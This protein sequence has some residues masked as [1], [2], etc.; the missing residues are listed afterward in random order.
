MSKSESAFYCLEK[1]YYVSVLS[2]LIKCY[3][4]FIHI[5]FSTFISMYIGVMKLENYASFENGLRPFLSFLRPI[6]L[7]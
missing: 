7:I 3:I 1:S 2:F 5:L 6:Y 4:I